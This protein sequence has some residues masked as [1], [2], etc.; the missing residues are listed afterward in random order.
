MTNP[1]PNYPHLD[2]IVHECN[3]TV[4]QGRG[5][6]LFW[7]P[8]SPEALRVCVQSACDVC[9]LDCMLMACG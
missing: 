8:L 2:I 9:V 4:V 3:G 1:R 6:C 7:L 5:V